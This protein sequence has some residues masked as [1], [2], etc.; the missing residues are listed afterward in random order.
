MKRNLFLAGVPATGK[1]WLGT[2]LSEHGYIHIDAEVDGGI[3]FDRVGIHRDWNNVIATGH[4]EAFRVAVDELSHPIVINWGFPVQYLYVVRALQAVGFIAWWVGGDRKAAREAY[5]KRYLA[6][7]GFHPA[8]FDPQMVAIE[9]H[10]LLIES[11]FGARIISGLAA[12]GSQRQPAE[13]WAEI[14][15]AS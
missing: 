11:V 13:M 6:G 15:A 2:W 3:D 7:R 1:T 8:N 10:W 12:D 4:A 9:Q 14:E 5:G